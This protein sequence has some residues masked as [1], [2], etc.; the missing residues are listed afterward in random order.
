MWVWLDGTV[1]YTISRMANNQE[2]DVVFS[3]DTTPSMGQCIRQVRRNVKETVFQLLTKIPNIRIG[4]VAHGDYDGQGTTYLLRKTELSRNAEELIDFVNNRA[5]D[6][7]SYT[8]AEAYEYVLRDVQPFSWRPNAVKRLVM[9]GDAIP[10]ERN[11]N[12]MNISW[13]QEA[14]TLRQQGISVVAVH[15]MNSK[16]SKNFF[17]RLANLTD[18]LYLQLRNFDSIVPL[19]SAICFREQGSDQLQEYRDQLQI[20]GQLTREVNGMMNA[21]SGVEQAMAEVVDEGLVPVEPGRF[22]ICEVDAKTAIKQ[23][24]IDQGLSFKKGR[25]FYELQKK[26]KFTS[27]K[28]IVVRSRLGDFYTGEAAKKLAGEAIASGKPQLLPDFKIFIQSTSVNRVLSPG[29]IFLYE[30]EHV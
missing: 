14:T 1:G 29:S 11:D 13:E 8:F 17:T 20:S 16:S 22:Q 15:C 4:L 30:M 12:P 2:I 26:E 28:E 27:K 6:T 7:V 25:G 9:I 23:F 3:F 24:V 10:H 5:T 19:F 18:G 21:L